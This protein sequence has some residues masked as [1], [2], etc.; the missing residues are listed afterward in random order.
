M[1][2]IYD[3]LL[4]QVQSKARI[5]YARAGEHWVLVQTDDGAVGVAAVQQGRTGRPLCGDE[6]SGM[7]LTEAAKLIKSWDL[8]KAALGLAAINSFINRSS[9]FPLCGEADAFLRYR[10]RAKGKK[11]AV[12]GRFAYLEDRLAPIC[13]LSVLERSPG[14]EDYPDPAC[15]YILPGMDIVFIT[16]CTVSN[17]T[18]PRLLQLTEHAFTVIAGPSTPMSDVLFEFGANALCG[19]CVTEERLCRQAVEGN[20]SVFPSGRMVCL[21]AFPGAVREGMQDE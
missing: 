18:L 5:Q 4:G 1:W 8:E 2:E 3:R 21:E 19:F 13:D 17:K 15:E 16:G 9:C 12:V 7:P 11:V 10:D 6:Y 20:H 14:A